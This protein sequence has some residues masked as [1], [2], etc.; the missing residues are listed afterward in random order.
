MR[1][2][3]KFG[4]YLIGIPV[5]SMSQLSLGAEVE[6]PW[7]AELG[8]SL[9]QIDSPLELGSNPPYLIAGTWIPAPGGPIT[10]NPTSGFETDEGM[11]FTLGRKFADNWGV[12]IS[13]FDFGDFGSKSS[14]SVGATS[15]ISQQTEVNIDGLN[16]AL[17]GE[18]PI[19]N[20]WSVRGKVGVFVYD[21]DSGVVLP[22]SYIQGLNCDV[23]T[24]NDP[25]YNPFF[26]TNV[27]PSNVF[28]PARGA[29]QSQY[30]AGL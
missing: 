17:F 18:I 14:L 6:N 27:R 25:C 8:I 29:N 1:V 16:L 28:I 11:S 30:S 24:V 13:Y 5:I 10:I 21:S 9:S 12:E 7:F 2:P 20:R 15:Y 19:S 22:Q 23:V 4:N 3:G 26:V